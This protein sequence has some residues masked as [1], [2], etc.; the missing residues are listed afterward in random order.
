M[1]QSY[2]AWAN[3][4][5]VIIPLAPEPLSP[6]LELPP[7]CC[8]RSRS[9]LTKVTTRAVVL[10]RR[11]HDEKRVVLGKQ[12]SGCDSTSI[13]TGSANTSFFEGCSGQVE[14]G[15]VRNCGP[16]NQRYF[17]C[18]LAAFI[19]GDASSASLWSIGT[20]HH[21]A[22]LVLCFLLES[23]PSTTRESLQ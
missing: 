22:S 4:S 23:H 3:V 10:M 11:I 5:A 14:P 13:R 20:K 18:K 7:H 16:L 15:P 17:R 19:P 1:H 9:F 6:S 21:V 2:S 8:T 12:I